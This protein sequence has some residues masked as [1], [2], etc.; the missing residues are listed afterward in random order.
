MTSVEDFL[1]LEDPAL[2]EKMGW[3]DAIFFQRNLVD[4]TTERAVQYWQGLGKP[5]LLDLDDGYPILP[6]SNPAH[7]FWI[8]NL[9]GLNPPPVDAL[10]RAAG[11]VDC[12]TSPSKVICEDWAPYAR[13]THWLPNYPQGAWYNGLKAR[14]PDGRVVVG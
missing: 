14:K 4:K 9:A 2:R 12:V 11:I 13:M 7:A 1:R 6:H 8:R 3:A 10:K 5:V